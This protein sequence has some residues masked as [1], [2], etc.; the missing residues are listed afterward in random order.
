M[1]SSTPLK[2]TSSTHVSGYRGLT[3]IVGTGAS[4]MT[5]RQ[6]D[7]D[8]E[9]DR[10]SLISCLAQIQ[11]QALDISKVA[12]STAHSASRMV[13]RLQQISKDS[14]RT[15][16]RVNRNLELSQTNLVQTTTALIN[17]SVFKGQTDGLVRQAGGILTEVDRAVYPLRACCGLMKRGLTS[18][19]LR[20]D[21]IE[22]FYAANRVKY[23]GSIP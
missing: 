10:L 5:D 7:A 3:I 6:K 14:T 19:C 12:T 17:T 16:V 13:S 21:R 2:R 4:Y 23:S 11:S 22:I 1:Y 15:L 9:R 8:D 20:C 18:V